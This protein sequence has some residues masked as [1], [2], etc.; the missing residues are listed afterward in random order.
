MKTNNAQTPTQLKALQTKAQALSQTL[1]KEVIVVTKGEQHVKVKPG[2]AYELSIKDGEILIKDFDLIA[3]KVGEDLEVL[4]PNDTSVVFDGYFEVCASDLS[5]LVSLPSE[6]GMYHV[7]EGNFVVLADGSEIVH[8][9]GDETALLAISNN[10]PMLFS[11]SF[12]EV[13][14]SGG[15]S[16]LTLISGLSIAELIGS[17]GSATTIYLSVDSLIT[18]DLTPTITGTAILANGETLS[19]SVNG[20][21]YNIVNG[22]TYNI[23]NG[24]TYN[25]VNG[26]TYNNVQVIDNVWSIDTKTAIPSSGTLGTFVDGQSYEVVATVTDA[27]GNIIRSDSSNN[28]LTIDTTAPGAPTIDSVSDDDLINA[29]ENTAGFNLTGTGEVGDFIT[30]SGFEAGVAD[31]TTSVAED[32]TWSIA[33]VDTDLADNGSNTLTATQTDSVGNTSPA[34]TRTITIDLIAPTTPSVDSLTTNDLTPTITGTA[35]L[36]NGETLSV[37]VNGAIYDNVEVIGNAWSIDTETKTPSSGVLGAFVD[38][39]SYDIVATVTD[40]AGN[41]ASDNSIN[42]LTIDNTASNAPTIDSVSNDDLINAAE[43]AAGFNLTG[44]GEVGSTIIVSGFETGV[45]DKTTS[46]AVDGT[47]SIAI[48]DADLADNGSN[49]LTATQTDSVG[50]TSPAATR[51]ITIDLIAPTTPSVD[52]LTTNDLTPTIT[53]T[54]TLTNGET[55]SVS[56]NGA[57]YD[58][59]EVIGNAWSIDTETKTPSSGVLGAFVDG[60]SYD[61]VATVTDVAG[62]SASDNSI[63]ELTIDNTASNAPTIDS[64]SNDDLINAAENAAGFNLTGTGEVGDFITVSGFE[65]GVADKTTSVAVDGTWSIAIVDTDLADNGS[66]TLTATQTDSVGNTSPAATRT[67]TTDLI[68]PIDGVYVNNLITNN[69]TPTITGSSATLAD[70]ETLSV[71]VNGA[72]Y[73]NV[74]VISHTW[75]INTETA[76]PS[77]GILEAFV[78]GQSYDIVATVTDAAGNSASDNTTNELTI[79]STASDVPDTPNAPTISSVSGDN[80]INAAENVAGFDLTGTG[81]GDNLVIVSGFEVGVAD[82]EIIVAADGTWSITI[83]DADLADNGSNT[84]TAVQLNSK[85]IPSPLAT[86]TITTDLIAPTVAP[87]V[88]SSIGNTGNDKTLPTIAGFATLA[89]D[90]TLSVS[91]N[92]ATYDDVEV[93]GTNWRVDMQTATPSS[94]TLEAF[95]DGQRYE[96]VATVTDVA[97]NSISDNSRNELVIDNRIVEGTP[98][99]DTLHGTSGDDA[100]AGFEGDDI[101]T[102]NGGADTF[103]YNS[104]VDGNDIITDFA[105]G[106]GDGDKLDM[107]LVLQDATS[108]TLANFIEVIDSNGADDG[109]DILINIDADGGS[110]FADP[111]ITIT[112]TD[113]GIAG[114]ETTLAAM[115]AAD[116]IVI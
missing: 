114:A 6:G 94:G 100:I 68:A 72:I 116:S 17:G 112:L 11:E 4:L 12:S 32:G 7:L 54:A 81:E 9:Y 76:I 93:I 57:I 86:I 87:Y 79:D 29:A 37:S 110:N 53:G 105:I 104:I 113:A 92:G 91:V 49:T 39:Q 102:G 69:L 58:N 78:D 40:V 80:L 10:Q 46:V 95:V 82:K 35:T 8:F 97:G 5:C 90:E 30:V 28:E 85:G 83:V 96:I 27:A 3:K 61:I 55:L 33:I 31:K 1:N 88:L 51:T 64:V 99:S 101:L 56:V 71:S 107:Y 65:A 20:A 67:I 50:N 111:N 16:P 52:S 89:D 42:E 59:V 41:S 18:N 23:V 19:V 43:N 21:T 25:I 2:Y 48:V 45:A 108:D 26:A 36:T 98:E 22:A 84:L 38:G 24:A 77:S 75:L 66:N 115:I 44:T 106:G 62:N 47:W 70:G 73:D 15:F 60:Q 103:F 13:Y 14:L 109:G 34:A 74:Q 63:N